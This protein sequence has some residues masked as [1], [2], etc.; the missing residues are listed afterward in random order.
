MFGAAA[1]APGPVPAAQQQASL[2]S[3]YRT[4]CAP[5]HRN[6]QGSP[7]GTKSL[8]TEELIRQEHDR[9]FFDAVKDGI[10][11][12]EGHD[13]GKTLSDPEVWGLVVK[14]REMQARALR[15]ANRRQRPPNGVYVSRHHRFRVEDVV[16]TGLRVPWSIDWL[17][18]GRML[19]TNRTGALH[20]YD[21]GEKVAE[22]LGLPPLLPSSQGGLMEVAVHDSGWVFLSVSDPKGG[23]GGSMTKVYRG[24][25]VFSDGV[26]RWTGQQ[27][28]F[29]ALQEHY[30]RSTEHFGG[31][32]AFD[33]EGH[34]FF[35]VGD[36]HHQTDA[37]DPSKP[38]GKVMR[39]NL[40]GSVPS[41]NPFPGSPA[42][43]LGHRNQQGLAVGPDGR[44]WS[45]E[46][47]LRGGDEL[48][49]IV[50][51]ADY[52][53]PQVSHSTKYNDTAYRVP[54]GEG[55]VPPLVR[56]T[57]SSGASGLDVVEGDAFPLWKGDLL[58][59]GLVGQ[60]LDRV[61]LVDGVVTEREELLHGLGRV[62]DIAVHEDG[63]VYVALNRTSAEHP[64]RVVRLVPAD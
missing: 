20:V 42:W 26:A 54:W 37:Q 25:I 1:L 11:G 33:G 55:F 40:D 24:K 34:V 29:E 57:P 60:N 14:V 28:V 6:G 5:C 51:G 38:Y 8:L 47:G 15:P 17:A 59:G 21:G 35:S 30:D 63:T 7:D 48:N 32:I 62:R 45:T 41:D 64:D 39:L 61:R 12:L 19:V 4:T 44:L 9:R 49:Q 43:S 50:K 22:V 18:D 46:H 56:W 27:T 53:W 2:S 31:K 58:A 52:G 13:F 10:P 16:T 36:R 3:L 23:A